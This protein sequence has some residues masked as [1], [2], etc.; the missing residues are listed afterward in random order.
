M[1]TRQ[2]FIKAGAARVTAPLGFQACAPVDSPD[3]H[4]AAVLCALEPTR[5]TDVH[6]VFEFATVKRNKK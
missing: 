2:P 5:F 1:V 6:Y 3:S 4:E